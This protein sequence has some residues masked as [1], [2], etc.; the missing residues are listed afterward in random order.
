M[1][2]ISLITILFTM[3]FTASARTLQDDINQIL[4]QEKRLV[5]AKAVMCAEAEKNCFPTDY[6]KYEHEMKV[7]TKAQDSTN[8]FS[9]QDL[10]RIESALKKIE[11]KISISRWFDYY[12][13]Y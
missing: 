2:R 4:K 7:L 1:K 12:D 8:V 6:V 13:E 11:E 5:V 9:K 3:S 10:K